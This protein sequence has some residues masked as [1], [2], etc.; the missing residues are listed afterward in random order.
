LEPVWLP[1]VY[2]TYETVEGKLL[3]VTESAEA[4]AAKAS[5]SAGSMDN[6]TSLFMISPTSSHISPSNKTLE[7]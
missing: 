4:P 2:P 5:S 7:E 1:A 3:I 6:L